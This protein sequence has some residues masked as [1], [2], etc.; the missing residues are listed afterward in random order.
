MD[1]PIVAEPVINMTR[2]QKLATLLVILGPDS[3]AQLLEGLDGYELEL[4]SMEMAK[5]TLISQELRAAILQE[6]SEL[7]VNAG[8]AILGGVTYTRGVLEKSVGLFRASD[9][10]NRVSPSPVPIGAMRPIVEMDLSQ[11]FNLLK[12]EQPQTIALVA[13]YLPA[14][15]TS[16]FLTKF[17]EVKRDQIIERLATLG[18][19]PIEVVE[20]L[21]RVLGR[22]TNVKATRSLN[23]TGGLKNAADILNAMDRTLSDPLLNGLQRRN[24]GLAQAVRQKMFTL[25]MS[26]A[27]AGC[28]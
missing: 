26:P 15:R 24:P 27:G 23:Q 28:S 8:T 22:K 6:F 17:S 14:E 18:P 2:H 1:D 4:V 11:L 9:I 25:P 19:T 3:A 7:A 16:L 10:I 20:S 13:S 5:V 12:D 21:A